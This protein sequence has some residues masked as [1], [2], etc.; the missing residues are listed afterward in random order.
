MVK[1][2]SREPAKNNGTLHQ[3]FQPWLVISLNDYFGGSA[4]TSRGSDRND[5]T[6]FGYF[7]TITHPQFIFDKDDSF[8]WNFGPSFRSD[9]IIATARRW[10]VRNPPRVRTRLVHFFSE[11][12]I[13]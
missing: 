9:M 11:T 7:V 6:S 4:P 2:N 5:G 3:H 10:R 13:T 12:Q 1:S 8:V